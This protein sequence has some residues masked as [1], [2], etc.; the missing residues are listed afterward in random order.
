MTRYWIGVASRDH[1][2]SGVKGGFCQLCHGKQQPLPRMTPGD[3]LVYYSPRTQ[4]CEGDS[5]RSFSAIG[6]IQD[7]LPYAFDM[8]DGFIPYRRGVTFVDC[9]P[10]PIQS[11][12]N[13]LSVTRE[14]ASWDYAF[15]RGAFEISEGDFFEIAEAMNAAMDTACVF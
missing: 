3:W 7:K 11:L 13:R 2:T 15:R 9:T 5:I 14:K 4:M 10:A 8:G 1:V 12:L 6:R